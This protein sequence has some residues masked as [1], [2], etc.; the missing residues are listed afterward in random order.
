MAH[1]HW[2]TRSAADDITTAGG[3]SE[4]H[5]CRRLLRDIEDVRSSKIR[6][7]TKM[8]MEQVKK[9]D[10]V[11]EVSKL[12]NFRNLVFAELNQVRPTL[13]LALDTL[14]DIN[15]KEVTCWLPVGTARSVDGLLH[16]STVAACAR[17]QIKSDSGIPGGGG[18]RR[19]SANQGTDEVQPLVLIDCH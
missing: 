15:P 1:P 16:L 19:P 3:H 2:H 6:K 7:G 18:V 11:H 10:H 9:T 17:M 13:K 4:V 5:D 12:I 8:V 14:A